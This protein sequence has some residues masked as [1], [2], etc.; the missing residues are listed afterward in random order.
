MVLPLL[1]VGAEGICSGPR[2]NGG[3]LV[4]QHH[5]SRALVHCDSPIR[6]IEAA[7]TLVPA[8][9][10]KLDPRRLREQLLRFIFKYLMHSWGLIGPMKW[11]RAFRKA[12]CKTRSDSIKVS[13]IVFAMFCNFAMLFFLLHHSSKDFFL[14]FSDSKGE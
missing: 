6:E 9:G 7:V 10:A 3:A 4:H 8:A 11:L 14:S 1:K 12:P 2:G 13:L 5:A